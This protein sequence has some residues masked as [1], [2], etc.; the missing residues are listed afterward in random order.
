MAKC[1]RAKDFLEEYRK[2]DEM[3][4]NKMYEV[5]RWIDIA[6]NICPN[7][8]GE[9]VQSSGSKQKMSDAVIKAIEMEQEIN[10]TIDE[11][12]DLKQDIISVLEQL[13]PLE[14]G[15]LHRIYIQYKSLAEASYD[16]DKSESWG[17][18]V[19]GRALFRVQRI[20]EKRDHE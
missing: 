17:S 20:L 14:Y 16:L 12:I 10:R 8:E 2:L 18:T 4:E 6:T 7:Y 19:H 11:L 15:L 3:I 1:Q 13:P 5:K 9:K